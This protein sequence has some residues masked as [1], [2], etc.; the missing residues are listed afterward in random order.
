MDNVLE[1]TVKNNVLDDA[2]FQIS[3]GYGH[4]LIF[5]TNRDGLS[6]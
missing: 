3:D 1:V 6:E 5:H 2:K 4:Y